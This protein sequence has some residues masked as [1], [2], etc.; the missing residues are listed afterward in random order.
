MPFDVPTARNQTRTSDV[1]SSSRI[2][3]FLHDRQ[4]L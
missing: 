4:D 2:E 1:G 3:N